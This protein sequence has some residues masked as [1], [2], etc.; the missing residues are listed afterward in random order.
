MVRIGVRDRLRI[1]FRIYGKGLSL[2]VIVI[3]PMLL[4]TEWAYSIVYTVT[5]FFN[6]TLFLDDGSGIANSKG[7]MDTC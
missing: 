5:D 6:S 4:R 7:G 1:S 3:R 2:V